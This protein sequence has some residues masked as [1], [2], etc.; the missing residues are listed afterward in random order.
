LFIGDAQQLS[1][2][3]A[4]TSSRTLAFLVIKDD[5]IIYERYL[6]GHSQANISQVFSTSKSITSILIGAAID[7]G[8][9]GSAKDPVTLYVPELKDAGFE[10]VTIENLLNM[11][12]NMAYIEYDNPF[13][14]H[15]IF[16]FTDHLEDEILDLGLRKNPDTQFKYKSGENALL[17]LI[18]DRA[19]GD[20]TIT[21]Y[22][23]E[24]FWDPLGM[25][26]RG[27]WGVDR[28][29]GLERTWCCLSLSA[30]DLAKLGRLYLHHGNWNGTQI[31]SQEWIETSTT[32]GAYTADEW[33]AEFAEA[34]LMNYKYQWWLVSDEDGTYTTI[35]KD[36]QYMYIDPQK[37]LIIIRLGEGTGDLG[38]IRIFQQIAQQIE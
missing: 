33:P 12:S 24:R 36:G 32:A 15:V 8:L 2:D 4:L 18:L 22:T 5:V 30:R 11:Q 7:D 6:H 27:V 3:E 38:W 29:D 1:L 28:D 25:E 34:G 20:R 13:D 14:K 23:Q 26:Q 35:G 10:K 37:D 16:N 31:L 19:L 17:G 9:I 21:Q